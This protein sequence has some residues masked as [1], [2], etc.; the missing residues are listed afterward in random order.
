MGLTKEEL[1]SGVTYYRS[2]ATAP[3]GAKWSA[4]A[5]AAFILLMPCA[6]A[7]GL[8]SGHLTAALMPSAGPVDPG[9]GVTTFSEWIYTGT[10]LAATGAVAMFV[11]G[12][13]LP[14]RFGTIFSVTGAFRWKWCA[15]C[16][17][18]ALGFVSL[19]HAIPYLFGGGQPWRV[20]SD[21]LPL[22][23]TALLLVP[24][25][26]AGE[27]FVFR[28]WLGQLVGRLS[29]T[30]KWGVVLAVVVSA[31]GFAAAHG[32]PDYWILAWLVIFS[33]LTACITEL[34]GGIEA[35]IALHCAHNMSLVIMVSFTSTLDA[36]LIQEGTTGSPALLMYSALQLIA[37]GFIL[38][39]A[40]KRRIQTVTSAAV[41][42]P[43]LRKPREH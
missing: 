21:S 6:F 5:V 18:V 2:R 1:E 20:T 37:A 27:E 3:G 30:K 40:K 26:C 17:G 43:A 16:L 29:R 32:S 42:G 7:L 19:A 11:G 22:L 9:D 14:G 10:L 25:Q 35:A 13:V 41:A 38:A 34:T 24:F 12:F 33:L 15:T 36:M 23:M 31:L 4:M 28:G 8:G 39:L